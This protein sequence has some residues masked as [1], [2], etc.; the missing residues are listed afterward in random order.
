M[1]KMPGEVWQP[2]E[3]EKA[4]SGIKAVLVR[5]PYTP[6]KRTLRAGVTP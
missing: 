3:I 6:G 5:P 1:I 2:E 4:V